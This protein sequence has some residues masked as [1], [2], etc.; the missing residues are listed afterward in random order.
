[1]IK[2]IVIPNQDNLNIVIPKN[3]IGKKIEVLL[4]SLDEIVVDKTKSMADFWNVISDE[5]AD[6]LHQNINKNRN[7]WE[8]DI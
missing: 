8:R 5:T 6:K 1:M 7:E 3:Y 4:Y 2:T